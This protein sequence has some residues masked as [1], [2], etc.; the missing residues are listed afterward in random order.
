MSHNVSIGEL[1]SIEKGLLQSSKCTPGEYNFITASSE[2]KTHNEFDHEGEY[3]IFAAAASGSL[4]RVHY[5]NG[6]FISSDLCFILKPKNPDKYSLNMHFYHFV[7]NSL[8]NTLVADTK[9][10]TSKESINQKNFKKYKLPYFDID[11]QDHWIDKLKNTLEIKNSFSDE[12]RTQKM[13]LNKLR[14]QILQEAIE[15]KL[16]K[17]FREQ[18]PDIE[19]ASELLKR[20]QAEKEQLIKDKKIKKQKQL[21]VIAEDEKYVDLPDCWEWCRFGNIVQHNAGK[22]LHNGQNSGELRDY[23]TTSNLYWGIFKLDTVKKIQVEEKELDRCS[24]IKG[25]LLI[26]EGGDVGRSAIWDSDT[27]ICFQ[28]HLHRVRPY[29]NVN[30]EYLYFFMMLLYQS[31]KIDEYKKGMGIGNLSGQSLSKIVIPLMAINEQEE[32]V[33]KVK[34]LFSICDELETQITSSQTNADELMRAVL[35]EAFTQEDKEA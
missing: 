34:K 7:F 9:S 23:I 22:T 28:N 6:K 24:A 21:P 31:R 15:G 3:L 12:V 30:V 2:W 14:Q 5:V 26:C 11:Q 10:G 8:R 18:N 17:D 25:D 35:K 32:I 16:T 29:L 27:T 13:L 19:P 33:K 20:I 4:G 1:F